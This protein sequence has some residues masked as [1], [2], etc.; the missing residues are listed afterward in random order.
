MQ[1]I[2]ISCSH[3]GVTVLAECNKSVW[4]TPVNHL[5]C[6]LPVRTFNFLVYL[7]AV[8]FKKNYPSSKMLLNWDFVGSRRKNILEVAGNVVDPFYHDLR[9]FSCYHRSGEVLVN[10]RLQNVVVARGMYENPVSKPPFCI[11]FPD[12][13]FCRD[14]KGVLPSGTWLWRNRST[15]VMT[16]SIRC[17]HNKLGLL[18]SRTSVWLVIL[19]DMPAIF[20]LCNTP[21][22]TPLTFYVAEVVHNYTASTVITT[23]VPPS[24]FTITTTCLRN[25]IQ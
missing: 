16:P 11:F 9:I 3:A 8:L 17:K 7:N 2:H 13:I 22:L 12:H 19:A 23:S 14:V 5:A 15:W 21:T 25:I 1:R 24:G 20:L 6:S 4:V 18:S 10:N